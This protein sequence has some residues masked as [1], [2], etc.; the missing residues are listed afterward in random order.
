MGSRDERLPV[1]FEQVANTSHGKIRRWILGNERRV[2]CIVPLTYEDGRH[3]RFPDSLD[4]GQDCE[5]VVHD[6]IVCGP[7]PDGLA[8]ILRVAC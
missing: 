6:D 8:H 4:R 2:H 7:R 5:L 3:P 1:E